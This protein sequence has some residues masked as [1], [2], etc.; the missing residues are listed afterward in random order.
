MTNLIT[1]SSPLYTT[2]VLKQLIQLFQTTKPEEKELCK[3]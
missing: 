3:L 2:E 1:L